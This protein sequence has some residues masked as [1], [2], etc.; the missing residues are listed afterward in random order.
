MMVP[1][2]L[3]MLDDANGD[4]RNA[5]AYQLGE[6]RPTREVLPALLGKLN[7]GKPPERSL[8]DCPRDF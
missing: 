3:Q 6:I 5:A 4:I 7:H 8:A 2:L 1:T